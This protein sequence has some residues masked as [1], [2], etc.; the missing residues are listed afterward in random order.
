MATVLELIKLF[1]FALVVTMVFVIGRELLS[2]WGTNQ[3]AT[4]WA[5]I[6]G[7]GYS[8]MIVGFFTIVL[9]F[10]L[11]RLNL[12]AGPDGRPHFTLR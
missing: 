6:R 8:I 10:V 7:E 2:A 3:H 12:V 1:A 5:V 9:G 4:G 11:T